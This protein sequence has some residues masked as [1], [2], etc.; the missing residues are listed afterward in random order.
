MAISIV[1]LLIVA[2]KKACEQRLCNCQ[3]ET[4]ALKNRSP[5]SVEHEIDRKGRF[6]VT[7]PHATSTLTLTSVQ[8]PKNPETI[9]MILTDSRSQSKKAESETRNTN[10]GE[11]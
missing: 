4:E 2:K 1:L 11:G 5:S 6:F 8:L 3:S 9:Q 7:N 10:Q